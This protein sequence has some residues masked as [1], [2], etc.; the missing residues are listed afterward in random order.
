MKKDEDA[1]VL[2]SP[3]KG[4]FIPFMLEKL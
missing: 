4:I 3:L 1:F 2:A